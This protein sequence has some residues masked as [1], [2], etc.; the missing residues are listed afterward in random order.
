MFTKRYIQERRKGLDKFGDLKSCEIFNSVDK[1]DYYITGNGQGGGWIIIVHH[2][3]TDSPNIAVKIVQNA[4]VPSKVVKEYKIHNILCTYLLDYFVSPC[5][6][7]TQPYSTCSARKLKL[8]FE[9][10]E[11]GQ[12]NATTYF[13][14]MEIAKHTM[15]DEIKAG[16]PDENWYRQVI[17]KILYTLQGLQIRF[18]HF[19]HND[20]HLDNILMVEAPTIMPEKY[21]LN[22]KITATLPAMSHVPCLSDFGWASLTAKKHV[23]FRT[24]LPGFY[25]YLGVSPLNAKD[26]YTD[27]YFFLW[28]IYRFAQENQIP[29]PNSVIEFIMRVIPP[30]FREK[31]QWIGLDKSHPLWKLYRKYNHPFVIL[32]ILLTDP[33]F[34]PFYRNKTKNDNSCD[35]WSLF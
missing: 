29:L 10:F 1:N 5:I 7:I 12:K 3:D 19:R 9:H 35:R 15:G 11:K 22:S 28:H 16:K 30:E 27:M 4:V 32:E 17:F 8:F 6:V 26:Y 20:L 24:K 13:L 2:K 14:P 23:E 21:V 18:P 31:D 33:F 25:G 34:Q